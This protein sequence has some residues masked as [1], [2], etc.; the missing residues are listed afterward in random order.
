MREYSDIQASKRALR[1][2]VLKRRENLSDAERAK[3][4]L[5][6]AE[7]IFKHAWYCNADILLGFAG[8]GSEIDIDAILLDALKKGKK[9][10][11]PKVIENEMFFYRVTDLNDLKPGYKGIREPAGITES[12]PDIHKIKEQVLML[13]PGVAF[14]KNNGRM[15]YGKGFYDHFL[16]DKEE[17][18]LCTIAVGYACQMVEEVP[19]DVFD[20]RPMQVLCL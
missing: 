20:I 2:E 18:Q 15:G 5:L 17:L 11:L 12:F 3:A 7:H 1:K 8:Y 19:G 10:Y 13:M 9:L 6:V 4:S 16:A 14:D